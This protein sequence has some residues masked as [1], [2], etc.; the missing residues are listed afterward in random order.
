MYLKKTS[1]GF[2]LIELMVTLAI[3]AILASIAI[4]SYQKYMMS[5]RRTDATTMLQRV[6]AAE[7]QHFFTNNT[8]T[9]N[10]DGELGLPGTDGNIT[11]SEGYYTIA[12]TDVTDSSYTLTATPVD[13]GV[14]ANDTDCVSFTLDQTGKRGSSPKA[15]DACWR[16]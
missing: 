3:V 8:Y 6:A 2:S 12:I 14:Q 9:D 11:S 13:G 10:A 1:S 16:R 4:P 5:S 7:E 15:F